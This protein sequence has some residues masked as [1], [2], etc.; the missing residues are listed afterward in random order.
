M[1][2]KNKEEQPVKRNQAAATTAKEAPAI[3]IAGISRSAH[4]WLMAGIVTVTTLFLF[5]CLNN[6]FTGWDDPGYVNDNPYVK[7]LTWHG[8]AK[9]FTER[10]MGNYHPLTILSYAIEYSVVQL[11]PWLYHFDSLVLHLIVTV[12]VYWFVVLLSGRPVAAVITALL[13]GIH[14]MHVESVAWISGRKDVLYSVFYIGACIAYLNYMVAEKGRGVAWY[15]VVLILY[16]FAILAKP[17]AVTLPLAL[18]LIDYYKQRKWDKNNLIEKIPHFILAIIFGVISVNVQQAAG[19]MAMQKIVYAPWERLALGGYALVT[20]LW[21]A[22]VPASLC[23]YYPYPL[24]VNGMLP[25]VY[26]AYP[27]IAGVVIYMIWRFGR[28][29]RIV[30]FGTL[31]FLAHIALL[32]QFLPVGDAIIADRYSYIPYLGLF[33]LAGVWVSDLF[34]RHGYVIPAAVAAYIGILGFLSHERTKVWYD[35]VSLWQDEIAKAPAQAQTAYSNLGFNYYSKWSAA[36][37]AGDKAV[38]YDSALYCM[39]K[40]IAL[41]PDFVNP[42]VTMGELMRNAGE[43]EA[44]KKNYYRALAILPKEPNLHVG[45]AILFYINKEYDSCGHYFRNAL[46]LNPSAESHGNYANY[47]S[48]AGKTDSAIYEYGVAVSMNPDMYSSYQNRANLYQE[49]GRWNEALRDIN[50]AIQLN[51]DLGELYYLRSKCD[52]HFQD[53]GKALQDLEKATSLGY[54]A[55]NEY[56]DALKK[57]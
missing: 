28:K 26:Y 12:L 29:S 44:A 14:P 17:V 40:A 47:L 20:Y 8:L 43:Y 13:F 21:K 34:R 37:N 35:S 18:L 22:V 25:V 42:Y 16:L 31:F 2:K 55:D 30:V 24:K 51:P 49:K 32:L 27:A 5:A 48:V 41:K 7:D 33:F 3:V 46:R 39:N 56:Y 4:L 53:K 54:K 19:A 9:I 57:L 45:M 38:Y 10:V 11:E 50:K 1:A 15:S 36:T 6:Q 52:T 23:C